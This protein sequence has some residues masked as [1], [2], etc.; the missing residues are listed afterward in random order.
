M[1]T[2]RNLEPGDWREVREI[3]AQGIATGNATLETSPPEW[4]VWDK[5]HTQELRY[6]AISDSGEITGWAALTPV[7][8]RCV[9]AGVAEVSV[10]VDGRFRG[11]KVGDMLLKHLIRQSEKKGY[12][13]LQAGIFSENLASMNLHTKNDFRLIGYRENIGKMNGVWRSVNLLERRSQVTGI[14]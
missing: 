5:S 4:E 12:W 14:N 1:S 10:Y 9:Y 3:Y 8:G 11:Q 13:T 2:I 6:V 7:S